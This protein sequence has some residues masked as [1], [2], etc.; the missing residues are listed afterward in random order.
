MTHAERGGSSRRTCTVYTRIM[1]V[2]DRSIDNENK[3]EDTQIQ[4]TDHW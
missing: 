2:K 1:H 3:G 4:D